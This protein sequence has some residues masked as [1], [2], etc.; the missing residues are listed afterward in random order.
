MFI[1]KTRT[2]WMLQRPD[3]PSIEVKETCSR[4]WIGLKW[5]AAGTSGVLL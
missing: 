5:L 3:A 4:V 2:I 1:G